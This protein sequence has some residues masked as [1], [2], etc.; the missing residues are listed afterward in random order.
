MTT[1]TE[2]HVGRDDKAQHAADL[3]H[4]AFARRRGRVRVHLG[5]GRARVI[6]APLVHEHRTE[7]IE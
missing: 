4:A 7:A 3:V 2:D 1:L 6:V 5:R